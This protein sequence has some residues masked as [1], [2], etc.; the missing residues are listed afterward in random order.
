MKIKAP[1]YK[2]SNYEHYCLK[3]I[4]WQEVTDI[5][6][7][8]QGITIVL[9]LPEETECSICEKI[10]DKLSIANLK[11]MQDSK[12]LQNSLRKN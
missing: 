10:F 7:R 6:K 2:E 9:S 1:A 8:K 5:P 12:H 3:F 11:Q 4:A